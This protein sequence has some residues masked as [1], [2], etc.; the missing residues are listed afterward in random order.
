MRADHRSPARRF[1]RDLSRALRRH[2]RVLVA[3]LVGLAATATVA[4][5]SPAPPATQPVL[6]ATRDLPAG[7]VLREQDVTVE[8]VAQTAAPLPAL[9][10]V[11]QA[12][13]Q[14]LAAPLLKGE[15]LTR[16]RLQGPGLLTG[17]PA[18][19][20]ALPVRLADHAASTVLRRGDRIDLIA[21]VPGAGGSMGT[22]VG[23]ALTVLDVPTARQT[24][25]AATVLEPVS[26]DGGGLVVLAVSPLQAR[27]LVGAAA[28]APLWFTVHGDA[29]S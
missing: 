15:P 28:D 5:L 25:V 11:N 12:T 14:V 9:S 29:G 26:A 13:G 22:V 6:V 18:T 20:V 8:Q 24:D 17:Q 10:Q 4:A 7:A 27:L 2:R 1:S 23:T 21:A 19:T 16:A 3:L